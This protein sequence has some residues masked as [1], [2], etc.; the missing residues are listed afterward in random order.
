MIKI[1]IVI[2]VTVIEEIVISLET[3]IEMIGNIEMIGT[4]IEKGGI[5]MTK[6]GMQK[7]TE[8]VKVIKETV[9]GIEKTKIG[10]VIENGAMSGM[11]RSEV[12]GVK[13]TGIG[14]ESIETETKIGTGDIE[15]I[16]INVAD[17][18]SVV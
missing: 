5:E 7:G 4:R 18:K 16:A 8:S 1:E 15:T 9:I 13:T 12:I 17:R 2:E 6:K 3:Q 10:K 11:T 14:I